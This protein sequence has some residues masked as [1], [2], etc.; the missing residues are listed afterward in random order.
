MK[1]AGGDL[2]GVAA[3]DRYPRPSGRGFI[4]AGRVPC[5]GRLY[6]SGIRGLRAA[7]SLKLQKPRNPL[8][9]SER[10][11]RP[12]GRGFIEAPSRPR[13]SH[14]GQARYPRPSGRGFIEADGVCL[15]GHQDGAGIRGLRAAASLKPD[16][17]KCQTGINAGIRG[18]RAAASLKQSHLPMWTCWLAVYPRP[19]GRGFIEATSHF[20][21]A[22]AVSGVSIRG[23]RAA[24][25][26]KR[27]GHLSI[28]HQAPRVSAAFGPRLH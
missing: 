5:R 18:L 19:S 9:D 1:Q 23:L 24:A 2:A 17:K 4:E 28:L 20:H 16:V 21:S 12:S 11:P 8:I 25:S 27:F 26:L 15:G 14:A 13:S 22:S 7:A 6:V 3:R 10:Y